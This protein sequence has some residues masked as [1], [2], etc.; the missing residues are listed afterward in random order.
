MFKIGSIIKIKNVKS[1]VNLL[2]NLPK[3]T[4]YGLIVGYDF[5]Y[6]TFPHDYTIKTLVGDTIFLMREIDIENISK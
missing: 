2:V 6:G 1:F 3:D 4:E 5:T